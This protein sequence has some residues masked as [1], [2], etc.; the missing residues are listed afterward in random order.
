MRDSRH[1]VKWDNEG[2]AAIGAPFLD[3]TDISGQDGIIDDAVED[4]AGGRHFVWGSSVEGSLC[5][6]KRE[7]RNFEDSRLDGGICRPIR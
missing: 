3:L 7:D 4:L 5:C 2:N 6:L 1:T